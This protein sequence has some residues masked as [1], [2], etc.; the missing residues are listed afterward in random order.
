MPHERD[1]QRHGGGAE[2][3]MN[4]L[5]AVEVGPVARPGGDQEAAD[6]R[7]GDY[8]RVHERVA[9]APGRNPIR[10]HVGDDRD[11]EPQQRTAREIDPEVKQGRGQGR[12]HSPL[13]GART[14][15]ATAWNVS[16]V[17]ASASTVESTSAST[18][19]APLRR[20]VPPCCTM[21]TPAGTNRSERWPRR[22]VAVRPRSV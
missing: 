8:D 5:R 18:M 15:C 9:P 16:A 14:R 20:S 11:G 13:S 12:G 17:T 10:D 1:R 4:E 21:P 22:P 3:E 19:A 7:D 6:K 2:Q